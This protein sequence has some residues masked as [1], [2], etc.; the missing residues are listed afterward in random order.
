MPWTIT[1]TD[2]GNGTGASVQIVA[3]DGSTYVVRRAAVS[4]SGPGLYSTVAGPATGSGSVSIGGVGYWMWKISRDDL[5]E[6]LAGPTFRR[7]TAEG[8]SVW[9]HCTVMVADRLAG[10]LS[11]LTGGVVN[12]TLGDIDGELGDPLT[13]PCALVSPT[14]QAERKLGGPIGRD[15]IGYPVSVT[16][17]ESL[18]DVPQTQGGLEKWRQRYFRW[19]ERCER[20]LNHPPRDAR[21]PEVYDVV[22]EPA[23][24]V[25]TGYLYEDRFRVGLLVALCKA[26]MPR[27]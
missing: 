4:D 23:D 2:Q 15:D 12:R 13:L 26:R 9:H 27:G 18:K 19:R 21:V 5:S 8:D 16:L 20:L 14:G 6:D 17:L 24:A 3:G 10:Q 11:G 1:V 7:T 22:T 25:D